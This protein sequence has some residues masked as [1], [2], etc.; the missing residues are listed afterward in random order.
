MKGV[1]PIIA[2]AAIAVA[3]LL[4]AEGIF[5]NV[6]IGSSVDKE[7]LAR[8]VEVIRA[9]NK[10]EAVKRGLP[11]A[12]YYSFSQG[13]YEVLK[14]GGYSS[15]EN[16]EAIGSIPVWKNKGKTS[17][18][19]YVNNISYQMS[20]IFGKYRQS[21]EDVKIPGGEIELEV[22]EDRIKI[23][24]S[25]SG[26]LSYESELVKVGDNPN[27]TT[28]VKTK[29]QKMFDLGKE[30]SESTTC[31]ESKNYEKDGLKVEI[32]KSDNSALVK[33][34]DPENSFPVYDGQQIYKNLVLQF[35]VSC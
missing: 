9:I 7:E 15:L 35:Y 27:V 4:V 20:Y 14:T 10:V 24:F 18:P 28:E 12:L 33:I 17:Y 21:S 13:A 30:I 31:D 5:F 26:L 34:E 29:I 25:S 11:Y 32:E 3:A 16:V 2:I 6:F 8:E 19:D 1:V 22:L 23:K